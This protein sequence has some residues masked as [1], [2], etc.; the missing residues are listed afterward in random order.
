MDAGRAPPVEKPKGKAK[1]I[2][3]YA[4]ENVF[5][6]K[7]YEGGPTGARYTLAFQ[8]AR[9][10]N[11]RY[12]AIARNED[13]GHSFAFSELKKVPGMLVEGEGCERPCIDLESK[14]CGCVDDMCLGLPAVGEENNRRWA[15]YEIVK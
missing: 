13:D 2:G 9:K 3:C 8:H 7:V 15:V 6:N 14:S 4:T 10:Q 5:L 11:K 1:F 12:F